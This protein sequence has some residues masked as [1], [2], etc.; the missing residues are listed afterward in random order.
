MIKKISNI[1]KESFEQN[2][3]IRPS[4]VHGNGIFANREIQKGE[5]IGLVFVIH[6]DDILPQ[7]QPKRVIV[8]TK[9]G[10]L[11]NHSVFGNSELKRKHNRYILIATRRILPGQ[12][13][14]SDYNRGLATEVAIPFDNKENNENIKLEPAGFNSRAMEDH[15]TW[16][17]YKIIAN[18]ETIGFVLRYHKKGKKFIKAYWNKDFDGKHLEGMIYEKWKKEYY[19]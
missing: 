7:D 2:W 1:L 5:R 16:V 3:E 19:R 9:M 15:P 18:G 17:F 4:N 13:I 14:T 10:S 11:I 12:E 6:P 8:R